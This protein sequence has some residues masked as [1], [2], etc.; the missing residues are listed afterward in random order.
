VPNCTAHSANCAYWQIAYNIYT[1][2]SSGACVWCLYMPVCFMLVL[3]L[4][5]TCWND[6]IV[7]CLDDSLFYL[8]FVTCNIHFILPKWLCETSVD[9]CLCVVFCALLLSC[10]QCYRCLRILAGL[11]FWIFEII[12]VA[13]DSLLFDAFQRNLKC[14]FILFFYCDMFLQTEPECI[15]LNSRVVFTFSF[16]KRALFV[17]FIQRYSFCIYCWM[18]VVHKN[19][20]LWP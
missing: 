9:D 11:T 10:T 15:L 6:L 3:S 16:L 7:M 18:F 4:H 8:Y 17:V 20:F 1:Q 19:V 2:T 13:M 5:I 14:S 12:C